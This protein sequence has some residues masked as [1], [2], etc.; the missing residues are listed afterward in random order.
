MDSGVMD[1]CDEIEAL[2]AE[3]RRIRAAAS[4]VIDKLHFSTSED[5]SVDEDAKILGKAIR[6]LEIEL[7]RFAPSMGMDLRRKGK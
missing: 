3:I 1:L 2:K 6:K 7:D 4:H 5:S